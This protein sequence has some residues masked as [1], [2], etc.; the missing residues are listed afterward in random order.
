MNAAI[1]LALILVYFI[2]SLFLWNSAVSQA[3]MIWQNALLLALTV[4]LSGAALATKPIRN[5]DTGV[6]K[7]FGFIRLIQIAAFSG[8]TI[9]GAALLKLVFDGV[10]FVVPVMNIRFCILSSL[11]FILLAGLG[12][13]LR[14]I[15]VP[16][17]GWTKTS[18]D[19]KN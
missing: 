13:S 11:V 19:Q 5:P 10:N 3:P 4:F 14:R 15:H 18:D 2:A 12:L 8:L 9:C 6:S 7:K 17:T 16:I 1:G